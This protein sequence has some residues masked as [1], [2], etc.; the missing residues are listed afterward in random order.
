LSNATKIANAC[1][2]A[3]G[4]ENRMAVSQQNFVKKLPFAN[5]PAKNH[6]TSA[7]AVTAARYISLVSVCQKQK[8]PDKLAALLDGNDAN[9]SA[10]HVRDVKKFGRQIARWFGTKAGRYFGK[11]NHLQQDEQE[12]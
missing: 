10:L 8:S 11:P 5:M 7:L 3:P 1:T 4:P 12:E 9:M 6:L 2:E